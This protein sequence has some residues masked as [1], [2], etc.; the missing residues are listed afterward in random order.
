MNYD[1]TPV[2]RY[3]RYVRLSTIGGVSSRTQE[4]TPVNGFA[5]FYIQ[6]GPEVQSLELVVSTTS[7]IILQSK[8]YISIGQLVSYR[9][10]SI[11]WKLCYSKQKS[12]TNLLIMAHSS[13][14]VTLV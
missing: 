10:L 9:C 7:F 13:I 12:I 8:S 6:I 3:D 11:S 1:G 5:T 2:T 4:H 14:V